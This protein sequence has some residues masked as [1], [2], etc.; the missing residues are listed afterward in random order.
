M[1]ANRVRMSLL[2][3]DKFNASSNKPVGLNFVVK[4]KYMN[5]EV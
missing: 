2:D 5:R 4:P 3:A 1:L